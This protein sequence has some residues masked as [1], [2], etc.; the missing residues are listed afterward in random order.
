[1]MTL[2]WI[3]QH[4]EIGFCFLQ[5]ECKRISAKQINVTV[6]EI[7]LYLDAKLDSS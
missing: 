4:I 2:S 6:P 3:S 7:I 1:M 5:L